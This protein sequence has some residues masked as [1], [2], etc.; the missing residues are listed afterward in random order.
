MNSTEL[1]K[2]LAQDAK[3][4]SIEFIGGGIAVLTLNRGFGN[5]D[6][7]NY[8]SAEQTYYAATVQ[9]AQK[10]VEGA[11]ASRYASTPGGKPCRVADGTPWA[12]NPHSETYWSS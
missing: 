2:T 1:Y 12:C 11:E 6:Y 7:A 4:K 5:T 9:M 8:H 10:F 3:V